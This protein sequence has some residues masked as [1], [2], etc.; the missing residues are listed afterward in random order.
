MVLPLTVKKHISTVG[1]LKAVV[2]HADSDGNF[3]QKLLTILK[4]SEKAWM[5]TRE[6]VLL[7]M[8]N[9]TR[10]RAWYKN[11]NS[12]ANGL[13]FK[14]SAGEIELEKYFIICFKMKF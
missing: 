8:T 3:K 7:S 11:E 6:H 12:R 1:D 13:L 10:M 5:E 2:H 4:M 9:D 14:C